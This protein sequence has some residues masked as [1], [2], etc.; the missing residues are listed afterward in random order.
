MG[1]HRCL[2]RLRSLRALADLSASGANT[3]KWDRALH[4]LGQTLRPLWT[5]YLGG[6]RF[7]ENGVKVTELAV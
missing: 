1:I 3:Q 5:L 4:G 6:G 2:K 7:T